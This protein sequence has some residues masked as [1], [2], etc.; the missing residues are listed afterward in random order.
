VMT[1]VMPTVMPGTTT[2][3]L[4]RMLMSRTARGLGHD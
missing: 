4:T 2:I 1:T 3:T